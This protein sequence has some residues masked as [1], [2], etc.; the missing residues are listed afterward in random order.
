MKNND[1]RKQSRG[2]RASARANNGDM[3]M[4]ACTRVCSC[5]C[6]YV[7]QFLRL[8]LWYIR[9]LISAERLVSKSISAWLFPGVPIKHKDAVNNIC[10]WSIY[11][12]HFNLGSGTFEKRIALLFGVRKRFMFAILEKNLSIIIGIVRKNIET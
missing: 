7:W 3:S 5:A 6:V 11:V 8:Y 9:C 10:S 4:L 12:L 1:E 2:P